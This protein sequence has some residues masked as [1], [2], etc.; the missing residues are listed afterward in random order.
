MNQLDR[1]VTL[2]FL[3]PGSYE[4]WP[5][6]TQEQWDARAEYGPS[7]APLQLIP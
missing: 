5:E 7:D 2:I 6:T 1:D 3:P 4:I